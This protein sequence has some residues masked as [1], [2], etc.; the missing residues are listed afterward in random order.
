MKQLEKPPKVVARL[1]GMIDTTYARN[2]RETNT[3]NKSIC[4]YLQQILFLIFYEHIITS[5]SP[6]L[7]KGIKVIYILFC[8]LVSLSLSEFYVSGS[9]K[10]SPSVIIC[11]LY[12]LIFVALING[13]NTREVR[14]NLDLIQIAKKKIGYMSNIM[15]VKKTLNALTFLFKDKRMNADI[16]KARNRIVESKR[17]TGKILWE[18]RN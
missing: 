8:L 4:L 3:K 7:Y 2:F 6:R 5:I 17:K 16:L 9:S 10:F 11:F 15:R 14:D 13:V 12:F 18:R 1:D